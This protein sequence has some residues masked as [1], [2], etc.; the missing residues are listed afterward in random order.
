[1]CANSNNFQCGG[2][3]FKENFSMC[4]HAVMQGDLS[5][6]CIFSFSMIVAYQNREYIGVCQFSRGKNREEENRDNYHMY[7]LVYLDQT[8]QIEM[9]YH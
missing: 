9:N 3:S 8:D 4:M 2:K 7:F 5:E 6:H 1:M